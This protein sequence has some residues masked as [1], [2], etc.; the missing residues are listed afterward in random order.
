MQFWNALPV[1]LQK[2]IADFW[3]TFLVG[4]AGM[5]IVFPSGDY[6]DWAVSVGLAVGAVLLNALR[7]A[8]SGYFFG[9]AAK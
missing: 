4:L 1:K 8:I 7:R 9:T 5:T 6:K 2:A 3:T